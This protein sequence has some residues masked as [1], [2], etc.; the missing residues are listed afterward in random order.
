MKLVML[1]GY[2]IAVLCATTTVTVHAAGFVAIIGGTTSGASGMSNHVNNLSVQ[3]SENYPSNDRQVSKLLK[4]YRKKG[5]L[6]KL[7][8]DPERFAKNIISWQ[9]DHGGFGL[10]DASFYQ[11]P[12][13]GVQRRSE[14]LSKGRELGNFDDD[15]TVAE[16]RYLAEVYQQT[17]DS[18]LKLAIKTSI[19]RCLQF[20]FT[21]QY[22]N[23]GWP[24]VY[25][26]RYNR[27][28]SNN[29]TLNDNAMIRTMVLLSD[30]LA[31]ITPF[32]TDLVADTTKNT[33]YPRLASAVEYLLK[34]QINNN[35]QL[36]LWSSQYN[37]ENYAPASARSYELVSKSGKESVGVLSYLMNWPEQTDAVIAAVT[38][39]VAWYENNK[40]KNLALYQGEFVEQTGAE[41]WYRFYEVDSSVPFFAGR[42]G[43]KKYDLAQVAEE[44]RKGYSWG[45]HYA[46][47]VLRA[48]PRYFAELALK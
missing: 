5:S 39:G 12:W 9:M 27:S 36:T 13:D 17:A 34:A 14:W 10:H 48:A 40:V 7:T 41:L 19:E 23:G 47:K 32:D 2:I 28:Y 8:K 31:N 46:S 24:Q 38:G 45:D 26:K 30:V 35:Q 42:D 25:P 22:T 4:S 20:I 1:M 6:A 11:Q 33:I 15:A 44:R 37:P 16:V 18:A 3:F 43:I 21:A 29:V